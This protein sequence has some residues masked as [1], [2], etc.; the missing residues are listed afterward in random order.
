M[1]SIG[2]TPNEGPK[3]CGCLISGGLDELPRMFARP[4]VD[5]I[6]WRLDV[7]IEQYGLE[8]MRPILSILNNAERR[9]V[10]ATNRPQRH[11]GGFA[12]TEELRLQV[13]KEAAHAGAEWVDLEDDVSVAD[14]GWFIDRPIKIVSSYHDFSATPKRDQL[15]RKAEQLAW[16]GVECIKL[17][18]YANEPEDNLRVLELIPWGKRVLQVDVIAFC[19]GRQGRWSRLAALLL[20]SP[21]TYAAFSEIEPAAPGQLTIAQLQTLWELIG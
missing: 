3:L 17:A 7:F 10:L 15:K 5:L 18:T 6:E 19:M 11:G 12:G 20:G 1:M 8:V 2:V 4:D 21:W 16:N 14:R 9:P 13:L